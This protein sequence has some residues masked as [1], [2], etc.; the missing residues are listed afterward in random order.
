MQEQITGLILLAA[1]HIVWLR[2]QLPVHRGSEVVKGE[3]KAVGQ[4]V[5]KRKVKDSLAACL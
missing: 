3:E 5:L 4:T 2:T 1:L